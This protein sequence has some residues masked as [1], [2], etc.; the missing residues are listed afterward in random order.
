MNVYQMKKQEKYTTNLEKKVSNRGTNNNSI[1]N[2][3]VD[4]IWILETFLKIL[5]RI[6]GLDNKNK[7]QGSR[8]LLILGLEMEMTHLQELNDYLKRCL[9]KGGLMIWMIMMNF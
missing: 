3:A 9:K 4:L 5:V 1:S 8:D 6:L 2:K 7:E